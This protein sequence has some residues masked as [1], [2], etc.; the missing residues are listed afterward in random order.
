MT[1]TRIVA[2]TVALAA[3]ACGLPGATDRVVTVVVTA[4]EEPSAPSPTRPP[5]ATELAPTAAPNVSG[6]EAQTVDL[7]ESFA[8]EGYLESTSGAFY[9]I[10]DFNET[11][12]QLNW[13]QWWD[14]GFAPKDFVISAHT[15]WESASDTANWWNSGCGFVF[16]E[17]GEDDHYLAYLGMDGWVYLS[18]VKGGN[19]ASLG[20]NAYGHLDVP[21]GEADVVLLVQGRKI[22]FFVNGEHVLSRDDLQDTEGLL[23]LTLL[24]GTN[25][26]FGTRCIMDEIALWEIQ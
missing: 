12:A 20:E 26:G 8:D 21:K 2:F 10:A 13:Y 19:W 16:R 7:I 23:G 25:K 17:R 4:T 1:S 3:V 11:W 14:T 15:A 9:P 6:L 18:R 22:H 5:V 24:S